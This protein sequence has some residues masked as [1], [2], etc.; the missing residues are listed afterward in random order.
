VVLAADPAAGGSA[1]RLILEIG[2]LITLSHTMK[3]RLPEPWLFRLGQICALVL[4][5]V[6]G[7]VDLYTRL[8]DGTSSATLLV[9]LAE[10][11]TA[12]ATAAIW[13]PTHRPGSRSLAVQA[14]ALASWSGLL[15]LTDAVSNLY[16]HGTSGSPGTAEALGLMGV[17]MVVARRAPIRLMVP[18]LV[19]LA[20][21]LG[22][23]PLRMGL[24][25]GY[26]LTELIAFSLVLE[27]AAAGAIGGGV[28]MRVQ[29]E[30][31]GRAL[32]TVRAEQRAEFARDLHDFIAHHVTG[33]VVQAQGAKLIAERDPARAVLALEQIERAGAET[34]T[35]M[36]RMVGVLRSEDADPDAPLAPLA[37]V[38]ELPLLVEGFSGK[39]PP[40]ARLHLE[41]EFD[42]VHVEVSSSAYRVVMEALTNIRQHSRDPQVVEVSVRRTPNW[43]LVRI[44]DDG[45]PHKPSGPRERQGFGIVGLEERIGALGGRIQAGPG[46][47]GGWIVDAALPIDREVAP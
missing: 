5:G 41:G 46:I 17:M 26:N 1:F 21:A 8:I 6:L 38:A 42:E 23:L 30:V 28:Y 47:D 4:M 29:E 43:L 27:L 45:I 24:L 9:G 33:I 15:S 25:H 44:V 37:G 18:A 12:I 20:L 39:G 36:R 31:R 16:Y 40:H 19:L 22:A 13:L 2:V 7:I 10:V 11:A 32:A 3:T 35:A 34:M 14:L